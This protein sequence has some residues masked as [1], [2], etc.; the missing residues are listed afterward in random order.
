M[1]SGWCSAP[2]ASKV[3]AAALDVRHVP[4]H[5]LVPGVLEDQ[6]QDFDG[7]VAAVEDRHD[8]HGVFL[9][10]GHAA[11]ARVAIRGRVLE[12]AQEAGDQHRAQDH[13]DRDDLGIAG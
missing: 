6:A 11:G 4:G 13:D 7:I 2:K 3:G 1:T 9:C 12:R 8:S 10:S 5:G